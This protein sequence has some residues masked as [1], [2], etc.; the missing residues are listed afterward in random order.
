MAKAS[1]QIKS[2]GSHSFYTVC[3]CSRIFQLKQFRLGTSW[4]IWDLN[5]QPFDVQNRMEPSFPHA[6][7]PAGG[8]FLDWQCF[9]LTSQITRTGIRHSWVRLTAASSSDRTA[10]T[11]DTALQTEQCTLSPHL[12]K[13][14]AI[15]GGAGRRLGHAPAPP[16][17]PPDKPLSDIKSPLLQ[18]ADP[19]DGMCRY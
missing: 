2:H 15:R 9:Y 8:A 1:V 16:C 13:S 4:L 5:T 18:R 10:L 6:V 12:P 3:L 17:P 14:G 11:W 19:G 7:L